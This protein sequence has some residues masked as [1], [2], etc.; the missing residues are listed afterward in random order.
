M[1]ALYEEAK[2]H[3]S[4][5]EFLGLC[6]K[7]EGRRWVRGLIEKFEYLATKFSGERRAVEDSLKV[8]VA[9]A[10]YAHDALGAERTAAAAAVVIAPRGRGKG[11]APYT[12]TTRSRAKGAA[13][14]PF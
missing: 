13:E 4:R 8:A 2:L 5:H 12:A 7:P 14:E 10:R 9:D 3:L 6:W 1:S 11:V